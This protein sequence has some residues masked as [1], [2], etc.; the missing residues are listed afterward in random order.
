MLDYSPLSRRTFQHPSP[1]PF[2]KALV[3]NKN[4]KLNRAAGGPGPLS[5]APDTAA[6]AD[7]RVGLCSSCTVGSK[8]Y[9]KSCSAGTCQLCLGAQLCPS[10]EANEVDTEPL[11]LRI[12]PW[13][14][15]VPGLGSAAP[16]NCPLSPYSPNYKSTPQSN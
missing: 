10:A 11:L 13:E 16:P 3:Y 8:R 12:A 4:Q 1:S 15:L 2:P 9:L 5:E 14:E 6:A 7:G